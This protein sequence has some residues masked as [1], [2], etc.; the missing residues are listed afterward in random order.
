MLIGYGLAAPD[1]ARKVAAL[2]AGRVQFYSTRNPNTRRPQVVR[3][4]QDGAEEE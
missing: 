3:V 2:E 4:V 1:L